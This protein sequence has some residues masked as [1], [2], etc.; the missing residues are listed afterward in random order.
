MLDLKHL[1]QQTSG[2]RVLERE[3]LELFVARIDSM[4]ERLKCA[5]SRPERKE[6]AHLIIGSASAIGAFD[7]VRLAEQVEA[8]DEPSG[9]EVAEL[10]D[11]IDRTRA[12]I[13]SHLAGLSLS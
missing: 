4:T 11:A 8:A 12:Y 6:A 10:T 9:S 3:V 1:S 7:V 5:R 2:N 13:A